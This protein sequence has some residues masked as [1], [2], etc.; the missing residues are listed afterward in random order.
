MNRSDTSEIKQ[1]LKDRIEGLCQRLLPTGKREGR[2]WVSHNPITNDFHQTLELK[3]ALDRDPGAWKDYRTG[4][5]GDVLG[6]V[7]YGRHNSR[8]CARRCH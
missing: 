7:Q 8:L 2:L 1:A 3:V 6:L 5:K 4:E